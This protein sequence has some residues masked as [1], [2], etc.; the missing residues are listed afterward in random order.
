VRMGKGGEFSL[1]P[2]PT[3]D[4]LRIEMPDGVTE[5]LPVRISQLTGRVVLSTRL[6]SEGVL[7]LKDL[8]A[9]SYIITIGEGAQQITRRII[10]N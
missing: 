7:H 4:I 1:Y 2:N 6:G 8:P 9:G 10:K 3:Q 5:N